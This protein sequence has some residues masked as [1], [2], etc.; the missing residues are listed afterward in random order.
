MK[1]SNIFLLVVAAFCC[2]C[3]KEEKLIQKDNPPNLVEKLFVNI[4]D[5]D[6]SLSSGAFV[7]LPEDSL[8]GITLYYSND[9]SKKDI[10]IA[11]LTKRKGY[12]ENI[13][14][15]S[16]IDLVTIDR[17]KYTES[18]DVRLNE[19]YLNEKVDYSTVAVYDIQKSGEIQNRINPLKAWHPDLQKG[20][21]VEI[22]PEKLL[23]HSL[24]ESEG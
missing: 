16:I 6:P 17:S 20:K 24:E 14:I 7:T 2:L 13:P 9:S 1:F 3:T 15:D 8:Y 18:A 4:S 10:V 23:C 11:M 21:L 5:I 22:K 12:Q 19:C